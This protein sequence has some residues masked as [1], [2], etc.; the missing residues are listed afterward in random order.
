MLFFSMT[1]FVSLQ[2]PVKSE[3]QVLHYEHFLYHF[4]INHPRHQGHYSGSGDRAVAGLIG[5]AQ[6]HT[7][8]TLE[9]S[10]G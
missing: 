10:T 9:I 7:Q 2:P 6:Q 8:L 5:Q 1:L 4:L 3:I